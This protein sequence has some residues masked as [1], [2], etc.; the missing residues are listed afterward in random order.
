MK[1]V[2]PKVE[3]WAQGENKFDHIAKCARVCY[4]S[5]RTTNNEKFV[6]GLIHNNHLSMLRH[7][8][9][10]FDF[11]NCVAGISLRVL[12]EYFVNNPYC[13]C[14]Y[15]NKN[16]YV[17]TNLQYYD[18]IHDKLLDLFDFNIEDYLVTED[19]IKSQGKWTE[20][21]IRY[22][23][24]IQTSIDVSRELNRV[25]PNNIA[26]Q[27]IRYVEQGSICESYFY[28]ISLDE[29]EFSNGDCY[30][31]DGNLII[32]LITTIKYGNYDINTFL[33]YCQDGF[34]SYI[35]LLNMGFAKEDARKVLPL[36]TTTKCVYT[37]S[38]REWKHILDLRLYGTTGRPHPDARV[39]GELIKKEFYNIGIE[40]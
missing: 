26:E 24:F 39:I 7:W 11:T 28:D 27:L 4:A 9:I 15:N 6:N 32:P 16:V 29:V 17:S 23:M 37:Y 40:V 33:N 31:K 2:K 1:I 10:Y 38:L 18:E 25:S 14:V 12:R 20:D 36:V 34:D 30:D 22:T 3:Y 5:D 13:T 21:V 19:F 35:G 8:S